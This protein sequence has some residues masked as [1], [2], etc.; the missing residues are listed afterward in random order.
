ML[1]TTVG[2]GFASALFCFLITG[3]FFFLV[4]AF[5]FF[6]FFCFFTSE[7]PASSSVAFFLQVWLQQLQLVHMKGSYASMKCISFQKKSYL[8]FLFNPFSPSSPTYASLQVLAKWPSAPHLLH[9]T[10]FLVALFSRHP[11]ILCTF[12]LPGPLPNNGGYTL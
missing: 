8:L 7:G 4:V 5:F 6:C 9:L 12:G 1:D 3:V 10:F 2:A 11:L